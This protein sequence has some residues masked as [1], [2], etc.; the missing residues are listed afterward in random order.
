M[1]RIEVQLLKNISMKYELGMVIL[2]KVIGIIIYLIRFMGGGE[3]FG[4][5]GVKKMVREEDLAPWGGIQCSMGMP[6]FTCGYEIQIS[7]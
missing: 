3:G 4:P 7:R 5:C 6:F 2:Y 1:P